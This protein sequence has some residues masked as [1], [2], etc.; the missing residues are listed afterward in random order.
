MRT[1]FVKLVILWCT[2]F[3]HYQFT[4]MSGHSRSHHDSIPLASFAISLCD[5]TQ[6]CILFLLLSSSRQAGITE[7]Y[8]LIC[9]SFE[10]SMTQTS[11]IYQLLLLTDQMH[12]L[13]AY[14]SEYFIPSCDC[15]DRRWAKVIITKTSWHSK[16]ADSLGSRMFRPQSIPNW[17]NSCL[18]LLPFILSSLKWQNFL[19]TPAP[20]PSLGC[21]TF[22]QTQANVCRYITQKSCPQELQKSLIHVVRY[23]ILGLWRKQMC[24]HF[25]VEVEANLAICTQS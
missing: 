19:W 10:A 22:H 23:Q 21:L 4:V 16:S 25:R 13:V 15:E 14:Q 1:S 8:E 5:P 7:T 18:Y 17:V 9:D 3:M 24:T 6:Q 2:S 12:I 11:G 20:D